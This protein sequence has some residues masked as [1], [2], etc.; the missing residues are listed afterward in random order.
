MAYSHTGISTFEEC[1]QKFK[2]K[3]IDKIG[4]WVDTIETFMGSRVHE[5]MEKLYDGVKNGRTYTL[6]EL[7]TFYE[8]EWASKFSDKVII[9]KKE[10]TADDYK[11]VGRKCICDY[12]ESHK[13]FDD[14]NII[15]VE[16]EDML[17]LAEGIEY[18][19]RIDKFACKGDTFYVCDYKTNGILKT[20]EDADKDR[21]LAMYAEWVRRTYKTDNVKLVWHML[22]F[23]RDVVSERTPEEMKAVVDKTLNTIREIESCKDW[24]TKPSALCNYCEFHD[25]CPEFCHVVKVDKEIEEKHFTEDEGAKLVDEFTKVNE[26]YTELNLKRDEL[27]KKKEQLK[28]DIAAFAKQFGYNAVGGTEKQANVKWERKA[29]ILDENIEKAISILEGNGRIS[30]YRKFDKMKAEKDIVAGKA[31]EISSLAETTDVFKVTLSRKK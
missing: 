6:D 26:Q 14:M 18:Y 7:L 2:F 17:E 13:P 29:K 16:T 8:G 3:Y 11:A 15:G 9:V 22:R 27:D 10:Y 24:T 25:V 21:Q 19:V 1:R 31:D 30:D 23:D 20:Q 5:T 28:S 12:Y 4:K